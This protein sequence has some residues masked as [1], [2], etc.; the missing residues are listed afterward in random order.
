MY[1]YSEIFIAPSP[2]QPALNRSHHPCPTTPPRQQNRQHN[3][4]ALC[5]PHQHRPHQQDA[6]NKPPHR[7]GSQNQQQRSPNG[8]Y[9]HIQPCPP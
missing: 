3:G 8:K 7:N 5:A 1:L 9:D 4:N 2:S 6:I